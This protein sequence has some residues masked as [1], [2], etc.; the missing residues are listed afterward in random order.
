IKSIKQCMYTVR[1][2]SETIVKA[3]EMGAVDYVS[4]PFNSAELLSRVKTHLELKTHRDHLE[5]LVAERT[6]ELAMTQAVTLKS[7]ATLAEYRDPETGGHIKRTQNYVKILAERLKT[8][9]RYNGYF[10]DDFITLLHRSA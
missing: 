1:H 6:Q 2:D 4:K 5:M 10:T 8:S 9:G 3:F 7:L